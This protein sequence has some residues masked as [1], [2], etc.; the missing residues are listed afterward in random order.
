MKEIM[1]ICLLFLFSNYAINFF[2]YCLSGPRF[3]EEIVVMLGM[4]G[5]KIKLKRQGRTGT[6]STGTAT[7]SKTTAA[8][9]A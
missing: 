9:I 7:I 1:V 8:T 6:S 2:L 3:R 5:I 4:C